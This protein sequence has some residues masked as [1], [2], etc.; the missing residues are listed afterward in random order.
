LTPATKHPVWRYS[1]GYGEAAS[2]RASEA[3]QKHLEAL[4]LEEIR[5]AFLTK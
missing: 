2:A 3:F 5:G 4:A 1:F